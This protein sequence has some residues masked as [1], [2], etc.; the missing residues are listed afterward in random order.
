M[1]TNIPIKYFLDELSNKAIHPNKHLSLEEKKLRNGIE[2]LM[3]LLKGGLES[4]ELFSISAFKLFDEAFEL[5][6]NSLRFLSKEN[7][8][9]DEIFGSV[10]ENFSKKEIFDINHKQLVKIVFSAIETLS[11]VGKAFVEKENNPVINLNSNGSDSFPS[12]SYDEFLKTYGL[13][14]SSFPSNIS[15]YFIDLFS[16][17]LMLEISLFAVDILLEKNSKLNVS[18]EKIKELERLISKNTL[19]YFSSA[20]GLGM[21]DNEK[22]ENQKNIFD[23]KS[24]EFKIGRR[25]A[26]DFLAKQA[27]DHKFGY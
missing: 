26:L 1:T 21:F 25:D 17:S 12:I 3:I 24:T 7:I 15:K 2:K 14:Y 19:I 13:V 20:V 27:Q 11:R 4:E 22:S 5:R 6:L 10:L 16:S 8:K 18:L 9:V 23:P